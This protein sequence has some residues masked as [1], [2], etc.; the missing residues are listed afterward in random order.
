M[1]LLFIIFKSGV[2]DPRDD[3]MRYTS[4]PGQAWAAQQELRANFAG[5]IELLGYDLPQQRVRAGEKFS[6][7]L[8]WRALAPLS[9]NYQSFIHLARPLRVLWGQED[10]LNPGDLPTTRW[11]LD[12]YVWDEYEITVA[13][14]TPPG[15]YDLNVGLYSDADGYRLQRYN[16]E[17]LVVSDSMVIASL[18]VLE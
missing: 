7:V 5:Q 6:V 13:P 11:P 4:P 12:K 15:E 18:E 16:E 3:W 1:I 8:Y 9:V 10:H 14:D 2:I 17:G